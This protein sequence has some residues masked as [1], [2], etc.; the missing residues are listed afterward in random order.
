M[1][2][3]AVGWTLYDVIGTLIP[4]LAIC[5]CYFQV[6]KSLK[7][8]YAYTPFVSKSAMNSVRIYVYMALPFICFLP[9][10]IMH[11]LEIF[12]K[13]LEVSPKLALAFGILRRLWGFLNLFA[14]RFFRPEA[15]NETHNDDSFHKL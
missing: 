8:T 12:C 15:E 11:F 1:W 5:Y 13:D 4:C 2:L 3:R 10:I 14:F 6:L 7:T 9:F